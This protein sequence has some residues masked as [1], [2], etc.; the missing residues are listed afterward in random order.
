M[1]PLN[2]FE[3]TGVA[4]V[5]T[6]LTFTLVGGRTYGPVTYFEYVDTLQDSGKPCNYNDLKRCKKPILIHHD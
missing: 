2:F 4:L 1:W 6:I 3:V 5:G